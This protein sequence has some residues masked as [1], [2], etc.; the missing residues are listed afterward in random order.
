MTTGY[1]LFFCRKSLP[2]EAGDS[3]VRDVD[4]SRARDGRLTVILC[5]LF[6]LLLSDFAKGYDRSFAA[7]GQFS[8]GCRQLRYL[9]PDN[10][11]IDGCS[12]TGKVN[13]KV[14]ARCSPF[15]FTAMPINEADKEMLMTVDGIGP[16]LADDILAYRLRHGPFGSGRDLLNM[17]GIGPKREKK[18]AAAFRFAEAQ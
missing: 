2:T 9:P 16:T 3:I 8:G 18:F 6:G 13:A 1:F 14:S 17:P 11:T 4:D 10:L 15:L 7:P 12:S 5:L